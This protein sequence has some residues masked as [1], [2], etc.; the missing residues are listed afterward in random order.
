M[1]ALIRAT[2]YA[3]LFASI[4]LVF[5]P[6]RILNSFGADLTLPNV[7]EKWLGLLIVLAGAGFSAS[8]VFQFAFKGRGT[9]APF[10]PPRQLVTT[11]PYRYVRNPM[12][13][14][15]ALAMSGAALY[16]R[17]IPLLLYNFGFLLFCH[18]FIIL[19][20]EPVL[21]RLFGDDYRQY[22][23]QVR[24]WLPVIRKKNAK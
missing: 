15:A 8:C 12:Y 4:I 2:V 17:S 23:C 19:Y 22:R 5:I 24:R 10:D 13:I 9:P 20:E 18:L 7:F 11:G 6:M 1:F 14:G 16:C 21:D 3:T